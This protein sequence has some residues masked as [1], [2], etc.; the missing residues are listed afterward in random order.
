MRPAFD[1]PV[2]ITMWDFSWLERRWPGAGFEDFDVALSELVERGYDA[3][4]IDP[5][6]HLIS[7]DPERVRALLP[8][9]DQQDWG[10]K[11]IVHAQPLPALLD[12]LRAC[13]RHDVKVALSSWFREDRDN[14][15]M[16]IRTPADHGR[17]W[18]DTLRHV[19][20]AELLD[21][22]IYVDL[23][24]EFPM[25]AFAPYVYSDRL[26]TRLVRRQ[27]PTDVDVATLLNPLISRTTPELKTWM[28]EAL[29]V[30]RD[31]Y[32]DLDHTIS[33]CNELPT[34][35]E[36][37]VEM[38]DVMELH[39]WMSSNEFTDRD[40]DES[41]GYGYEPFDPIGYQNLVARG[42]DEYE[43][44]Q[45][46]YDGGLC[47]AI[48]AVADWSRASGKGLYTTEGWALINFKDWPGLDWDWILDLNARAVEYV[49]GTG[50]WV[51]ITTS[52]FCEPQF[53]GMW[54]EI[55]WHQRLTTMIKNA[56]I[57]ADLKRTTAL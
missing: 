29:A 36:Q 46:I 56:P 10:A 43:R 49:V 21:T 37:D 44:D 48:D 15:R 32:P 50:R 38:L 4:R 12:F 17:V 25:P 57:D 28:R 20:H 40:Y 5:Y 51:G 42:R 52:N 47:A 53:V 1:R 14:T 23:C 39:I 31:A 9:W 55:D 2:A 19:E 26:L 7:A 11:A 41:I 33:F 6:P 13:A 18:V 45:A 30:V 3:V 8:M 24:N 35:A 16:R 22:I 54:R 27:P 34:W